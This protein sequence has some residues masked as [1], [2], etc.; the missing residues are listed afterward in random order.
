MTTKTILPWTAILFVL[1]RVLVVL[2]TGTIDS[3]SAFVVL[4]P[5]HNNINTM[6]AL[7][8]FPQ[9]QQQQRH[10]S[11]SSTTLCLLLDVPDGF[12]TLTFP[13]LG[14]LLSISKNFA[15][16][17]MEE[18]AW[19]QRLAEARLQRLQQDPTLT[20]LDLRRQ[21]AAMEWSAYG[22]PAQLEREQQREQREQEE[23]NTRSS[24]SSSRS[25]KRVRVMDRR[26][27]N[28]ESVKEEVTIAVDPRQYCMTTDEIAAF[29]L[30]FGVQYDP[31]YDDPY[32]EE[33][34]PE[35]TYSID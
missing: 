21:E 27:E 23:S 10:T 5:Y 35:G 9:Q 14:I 34:L 19:E 6:A 16:I 30:E 7:R 22:K 4:P 13:M 2:L 24:S 26:D 15:R 32:V 3:S 29:E 33:E 12:F 18:N 8:H 25:K 20:E 11:S 31:Y 1:L 28:V 17:R